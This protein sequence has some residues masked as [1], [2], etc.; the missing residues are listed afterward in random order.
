MLVVLTAFKP[1]CL[2]LCNTGEITVLVLN[3]S[4]FKF[5]VGIFFIFICIYVYIAG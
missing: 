1:M 5:Y 4:L 2:A 3:V